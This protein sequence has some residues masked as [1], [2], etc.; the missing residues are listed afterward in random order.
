MTCE[1]QWKQYRKLR[2]QAFWG[3]LGGAYLGRFPLDLTWLIYKVSG[4]NL[5]ETVYNGLVGVSLVTA[6][7]FLN[8]TWT[9][10]GTWPCP[11]CK[12]PF[13]IVG[14]HF[15]A[16]TLA[17]PFR[18]QMCELRAKEMDLSRRIRELPER[19]WNLHTP[20]ALELIQLREHIP[21]RDLNRCAFE[22]KYSVF[23][24]NEAIL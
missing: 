2:W 12:L 21:Q 8:I 15:Y 1:E 23:W 11:R 4:H 16:L 9:R 6:F 24:L 18:S 20:A 5:P 13:C 10:W 19:R 3:W 17:Q 7:T 14:R 22:A